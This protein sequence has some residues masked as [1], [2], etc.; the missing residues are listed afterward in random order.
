MGQLL[1]SLINYLV[2]ASLNDDAESFVRQLALQ[3]PQH[4]GTLM[5]IAQP[6]EPKRIEK[7]IQLG[8][9]CGIEMDKCEGEREAALKIARTML[10][11]GLDRSTVMKITGL[12]VK[13]LSQQRH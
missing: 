2:Q 7:G 1:V 5:T 11:N 6:Q 12:S 8:E 3:V 10:D 9:Q 4:G 13:D